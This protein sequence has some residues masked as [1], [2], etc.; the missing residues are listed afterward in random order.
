[1]PISRVGAA[2]AEATS[3][4]IPAHQAGD[5][6]ICAAFRDGST[7]NP[8]IPTG[9]NWTTITNSL[10]GTSCSVSAAYK[11]ARNSSETSGTWTN[12][13]GLAVVVYRGVA[14]NKTPIGSFAGTSGTTNTVTYPTNSPGANSLNT[15]RATSWLIS[16]AFHRST[17]TTIETA[18]AG[19]TNITNTAGTTAEYAAHD[20]NG[21]RGSLGSWPQTT[22][23]ITGTASGWITVVGEIMA[24]ENRLE[25]FKF[26][27]V[28]GSTSEKIK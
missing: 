5:L 13:S 12:A 8:T 21:P 26:F 28:T 17:N 1:M 6:I 22:V 27:D 4:T 23:S 18:P 3:I 20:S 14:T 15:C 16:F 11:R 25:N 24:E 9:V 7:T 10:D 19:M 2:S